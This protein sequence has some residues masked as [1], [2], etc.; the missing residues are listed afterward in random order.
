[1]HPT[2][3]F[4][5]TDFRSASGKRL[6]HVTVLLMAC[7]S[8]RILGQPAPI[9]DPCAELNQ[10]AMTQV[11]NGKLKE[12]ELS[13]NALLTS[14]A[15]Q[16]QR[17]CAGLV[18]NNMAVFV[19]ISGQAADGSRLAEQ[20]IQAL[21]KAY[22]SNDPVLLRP[23]QVLASTNFD[24]GTLGKAREAFKRMQSI[25]IQRPEDRALVHGMAAALSEAEGR[26]REAE[27]DYLAALQ[28]W[29]DA[30]RGESA[31]TSAVLAG[32]GSLYIK[33]NRLSEA[34]KV[35]DRALAMLN[36]AKD[37]VPL[38]RTKLL[39]LHAVL[40]ARQGDWLAAEQ[41]LHDALATAD[42]EPWV[43][44]FVLR[45]ILTN[46]AAVLRK[47]HR[48]REARSIEARAVAIPIGGGPATIVD[49]TE[50]LHKAKPVKK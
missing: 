7:T 14:G 28:A 19:S 12:A 50:L 9:S 49:I 40:Q 37:A 24:R 33:E 34:A 20:S 21:E 6:G 3:P 18:L 29:Q 4:E 47:N 30:G 44:P 10:T 2:Q 27:A 23:L 45:S 8:G 13:V 22:S 32:L 16:A 43:D 11:A 48:R 39:L 41:Y 46:Y 31:D 17:A 42:R 15:D 36:T 26:L 5:R 25:R 35:L 1:M 38:D